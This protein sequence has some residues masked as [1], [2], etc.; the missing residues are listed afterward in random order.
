MC[1]E[2]SLVMVVWLCVCKFLKYHLLQEFVGYL[3]SH[4]LYGFVSVGFLNITCSKNVSGNLFGH[5]C[6]ALCL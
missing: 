2:I 1:R 3:F 4:G 5:G 6:M